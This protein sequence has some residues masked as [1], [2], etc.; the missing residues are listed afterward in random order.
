MRRLDDGASL[1]RLF[2]GA[3]LLLVAGI[4]IDPARG[5]DGSTARARSWSTPA[6]RMID[7]RELPAGWEDGYFGV[8]TD[9]PGQKPQ[10]D[11]APRG[12]WPRR[13]PAPEGA[14]VVGMSPEDSGDVRRIAVLSDSASQRAAAVIPCDTPPATCGGRPRLGEYARR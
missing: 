6:S 2:D 4:A 7:A 12:S 14:D 11:I 8:L 9:A 5:T 10:F 1:Q 13:S 3:L